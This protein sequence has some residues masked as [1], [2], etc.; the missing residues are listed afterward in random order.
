MIKIQ[1]LLSPSAHS[2]RVILSACS[3]ILCVMIYLP[4]LQGDF[5]H[6]DIPN[7]LDN[8]QLKIDSLDLKSILSAS[9]SSES[10]PL[11]RPVSMFSFA[12]NYYYSEFNPF[13]Y[14]LVNLIIHLITGILL[15]LLTYLLL[16]S[17]EKLT[18]KDTKLLN[19]YYISLLVATAWLVSP[20][21]LTGVLYII[22][23][24]TSLA[25]LF[26]VAGLCCYVVARRSMMFDKDFFALPIVFSGIF[27]IIALFCKETAILNIF[28]VI[29]IEFCLFHLYSKNILSTKVFR[30]VFILA[31]ASPIIV[32]FLYFITEPGYILNG[33]NHRFFTLTERLLTEPRIL[34][35]YL[36]WIIVP[37]ISSL[38]LYHDD[39]Q[40]SHS[41]L[42]PITTLISIVCVSC[43]AMIA[44]YFRRAYPF[45]SFSIL[46][47]LAS[48]ILESTVFPL[49]LIYEHRNYL[50]SYGVI[51][52]IFASIFTLAQNK[53][54]T[55]L[56]YSIL[57]VWVLC[58]SFSTFIRSQ[59]W[60]SDASFAYHEAS[61]H[62][63]SARATFALAKVYANLTLKEI[64]NE[65]EKAISLFERSA[66]YMPQEIIGE[67]SAI[68]F[69]SLIKGKNK[70]SWIDSTTRKL[71]EF[72]IT[73][74]TIN[75]LSELNKCTL[76]T[77]CNINKNQMNEF[78][79]AALS[80]P[81]KY[82]NKNK[83]D[84]LTLYAKFTADVLGDYEKAYVLMNNAISISPN[85]LQYKINLVTLLI[86][87]KKYEDA[88]ILITAIEQD[89]TLGLHEKDLTYFKQRLQ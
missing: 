83:S 66:T 14:K 76:T 80:N 6:D 25:S 54:N 73:H 63:T 58:I 24:M 75:S 27:F 9:L 8:D 59:Q 33:Y 12:I 50:A 2:T 22:Q 29:C 20:I 19:K 78:Y 77:S 31:T 88:K 86:A 7:L 44:L 52:G 10:G 32:V 46:F 15:F 61:H 1:S 26:S 56:I 41:I 21:N 82:P 48:H 53:A 11:K 72:P 42:Q 64:M 3:L 68:L 81:H 60:S 74:I 40:I 67:T 87:M 17:Y 69:T 34:F 49:E 38:G 4:G 36:T 13:T 28:Y 45:I 30:Y 5:L 79:I 37:N 65:K 39:I 57:I 89:D 16:D 18:R 84:L 51:F 62:P 71:K 70:N 35:H 43:L 55:K 47:F 85:I 23:R